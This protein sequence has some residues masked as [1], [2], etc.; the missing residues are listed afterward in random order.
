MAAAVLRGDWGFIPPGARNAARRA[1]E[2]LR[3]KPL[4]ASPLCL[5]CCLD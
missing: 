1:V 4:V 5:G 2:E 3:A